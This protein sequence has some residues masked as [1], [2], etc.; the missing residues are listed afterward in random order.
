MKDFIKNIFYIV[1]V[2]IVL[3][4][5]IVTVSINRTRPVAPSKPSYNIVDSVFHD[6]KFF[7]LNGQ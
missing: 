1:L 4:A 5:F 2:T 7:L 3:C 6:N